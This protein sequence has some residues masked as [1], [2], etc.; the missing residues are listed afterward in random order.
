MAS[1]NVLYHTVHYFMGNNMKRRNFGLSL[2]SLLLMTQAPAFA[3]EKKEVCLVVPF[4]PGG[5][6]DNLARSEVEYLSKNLGSTVW[7]ANRPGAGGNIGTS[8]VVQAAPDGKTFGYVT[9]G[10]FCVNPLL[11]KTTNFDP[12]KDLIPVG[13]LSKIG[14]IM[15]LNPKAIPGVTDLP[16]LIKY[17]K[18]H[19][20][21]VNFASSGVGTTSHL[22][23]QYFAQVTG[24]KLTHIPH[25]GGA[26]ALVEVLAGRI[27]FMIDVSSNVLPHIRKGAL[28]AL[29]VTTPE[30]L[31]AA[32]EVP[33]MKEAGVDGYELYAWDGFVL[34]KGTPAPVVEKFS[35]AIKAL[36]NS[37]DAKQKILKLGAEPVFSGAD[38]FAA[39]IAAEKP[40]WNSLV[41]EIK[42][43]SH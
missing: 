36:K 37:E 11:Y 5:G 43:D 31:T 19:P 4:P 7:I 17:A 6:G 34:P 18:E 13:Q 33:T 10:I 3:Q 15:V 28:K 22:A 12:M 26:A 24:T 32:P 39:F 1:V 25:A 29:A 38:E 42:A 40:K 30:R 8:S 16:S 14:L 23:G 35:N 2:I 9:N 21:K 20:G 27:P 41:S